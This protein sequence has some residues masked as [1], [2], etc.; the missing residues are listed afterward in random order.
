M[1]YTRVETT[2]WEQAEFRLLDEP[3][4]ALDGTVYR[5]ETVRR[6]GRCPCT[7]A[8]LCI[9]EQAQGRAALCESVIEPE[10][11]GEWT[12]ADEEERW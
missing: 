10:L 4:T 6:P 8:V 5:W 9:S 3:V 7:W 1:S 11:T 2:V 12:T